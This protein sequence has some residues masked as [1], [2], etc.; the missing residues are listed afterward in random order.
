MRMFFIIVYYA[1]TLLGCTA[2]HTVT[3]VR[4]DID[5][6]LFHGRVEAREGVSRF[7]CIDSA[8][9]VCRFFVHDT[10]CDATN[11]ACVPPV[12]DH[13]DVAS[14]EAREVAGLPRQVRICLAVDAQGR[15]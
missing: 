2:P 6:R 3:D 10:R 13:L 5:G 15:C 7:K 9:G 4:S 14:G 1:A 12:I 8:T 11:T